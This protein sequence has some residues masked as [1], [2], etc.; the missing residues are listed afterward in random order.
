MHTFTAWNPE[1]A[2]DIINE[3]LLVSGAAL[4]ILQALQRTFGHISDE[5]IRMVAE[6]LNLTRAEVYG[7]VTFYHDFRRQPPGRHVVK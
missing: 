4:P 3:H 2:R 6:A 1:S 7:V 5:A